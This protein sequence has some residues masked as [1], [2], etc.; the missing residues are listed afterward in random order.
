[1]AYTID[2]ASTLRAA[3]MAAEIA[4]STGQSYTIGGRMLTRADARHIAERLAFYDRILTG[5]QSGRGA[6]VSVFRVMPRD[7]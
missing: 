4:V 3:W 7:L 5:L 1:M 6:G 2:E